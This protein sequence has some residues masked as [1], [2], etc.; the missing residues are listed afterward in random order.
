MKP[1]P[2]GICISLWGAILIGALACTN[3]MPSAVPNGSTETA[4]SSSP[5]VI[6]RVWVDK[7]GRVIGFFFATPG[8]DLCENRSGTVA[9]FLSPRGGQAPMESGGNHHDLPVAAI[10]LP[11]DEK[12]ADEPTIQRM[13]D[14]M[15]TD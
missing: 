9:V 15:S 12:I 6:G 1:K 13:S 7:D 2:T 4:A 5:L 10:V 3:P 8:C 14:P 11:K